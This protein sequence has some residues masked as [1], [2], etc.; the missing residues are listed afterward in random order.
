M[1]KDSECAICGEDVILK[2]IKII[3]FE[4]NN[5]IDFC[6][7]SHFG[8]ELDAYILREIKK[9]NMDNT[10]DRCNELKNNIRTLILMYI[11]ELEN[12]NKSYCCNHTKQRDGECGKCETCKVLY[13]RELEEKMI[14][15]YMIQ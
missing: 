15:K 8:E 4:I 3:D 1:R 2:N 7:S 12:K 13:Y 6:C 9:K 14:A 11:Y 5:D 10:C